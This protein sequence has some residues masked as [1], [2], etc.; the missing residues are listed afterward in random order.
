[1]NKNVRLCRFAMQKTIITALLVFVALAV[2]AQEAIWND[3][4]M[5]YANAPIIKVNRVAMYADRTD[6]SL[7]IDFRKGHRW[8]LGR[9]QP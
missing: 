6:V 8:A 2:Q 3:V 9:E 4:V 1:M 5:G 7:H